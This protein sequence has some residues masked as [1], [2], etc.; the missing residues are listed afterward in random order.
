LDSCKIPL[1]EDASGAIRVENTRVTLDSVVLAYREGASAEEIAERFPAIT[2]GAVYA[3]ITFYLQNRTEIEA[4]LKRREAEAER[5]RLQLES[6][7]EAKEFR[8]RLSARMASNGS[9]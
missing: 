6:R 9:S 3:A 1:A 4:Y 8:E 2:L 7:P 5:V